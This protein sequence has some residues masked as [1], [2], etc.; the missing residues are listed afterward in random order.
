MVTFSADSPDEP[1]TNPK[2][3]TLLAWFKLNQHVLMQET[4]SMMRYQ[5][6]MFRI[7]VTTSGHAG[8]ATGT[9]VV[10]I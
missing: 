4:L 2:D 3:T 7:N 6:T 8:N 1:I 9:L 5:N 10:Y